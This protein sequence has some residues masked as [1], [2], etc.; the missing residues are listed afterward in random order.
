MKENNEKTN[1]PVEGCVA[2]SPIPHL[3]KGMKMLARGDYKGLKKQ[4]EVWRTIR[5]TI[6]N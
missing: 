2:E 1:L 6:I 4:I 3:W 5:R